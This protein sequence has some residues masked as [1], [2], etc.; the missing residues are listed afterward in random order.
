MFTAHRRRREIVAVAVRPCKYLYRTW[1][2]FTRRF[3]AL[4]QP[5]Y[6]RPS[7]RFT[8]SLMTGRRRGQAAR[9]PAMKLPTSPSKVSAWRER[10]V[11][12][13]RIWFAAV[14]VELDA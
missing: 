14:P 9:I 10:S 3:S 1:L 7:R 11:A 13:A 5:L 6:R 8:D 2:E 4:I 12:A